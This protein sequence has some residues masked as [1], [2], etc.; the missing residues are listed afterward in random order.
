MKK[1]TEEM[2]KTAGILAIIVPDNDEDRQGSVH[3]GEGSFRLLKTLTRNQ[4]NADDFNARME[5]MLQNARRYAEG[6]SEAS[7]EERM[8]WG[9]AAEMLVLAQG[10]VRRMT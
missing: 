3:D 1:D 8:W 9:K 2:E 4:R 5:A 6:Q 7:A 10:Y